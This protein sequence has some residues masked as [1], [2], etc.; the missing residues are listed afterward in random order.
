MNGKSQKIGLLTT[1]SLVV[2][3]M[4]GV[5]I[6]VLPAVL[7]NYGSISLFG[8][9]FT[10]TGALILAKIFS[11]FSKIIVSKSG[12]PYVYSKAGFGDFIGFL[13]AWGYWIACWVSNGAVAIAIIGAASFFIPELATNSALSV[14]LGLA[15]I[16]IFT[17]VNTR[18]IKESG[19]IQLITT[20]IKVLPLLFIILFGIFFFKIDNLPAFNLT[21]E[22]NFTTLSTVATLTLYAFL[23]IECAT[24]PAGDI[25]DPEKTIPRAT[26][27]GTIIV[28]ILYILGTVVLFGI[29]P[30][31]ILQNSPAPFAEA[32]KIIGGNYGGYFVAIGVLISGIGVLNGWILITGQISMATAKD[33]LFPDFFKKENK[34]GAPVNGFV[35]GGILSSIVMLMN[36]TEGLVEQ[37]EFIIQLTTLVVLMPY[38][39]TAAAYALIVIEKNL[40]TNS[41]VKTFVLSTLGF[42]YSL[43]AIYGSG[44][45]TV[46][47]GFLLL[48]IGIP[49]YIYMKWIKNKEN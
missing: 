10:A 44:S 31:E 48:L 13:V 29:L 12:G 43:W 9:L 27:L 47:Y 32:A 17:W 33:N 21:G 38:L 14:S 42:S 24:I 25:K 22:S 20:V 3:N 4:I 1:T 6:F 18:G 46:F 11:N 45:D 2:G 28:T 7:S 23:G 34:K 15:L 8:W 5:G 26:M 41:W 49:V 19:K 30:L 35:I 37:F 16:W 36:Y 39:F 40:H